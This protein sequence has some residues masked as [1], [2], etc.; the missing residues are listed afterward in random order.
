MSKE[1]EGSQRGTRASQVAGVFRAVAG[2]DADF[3]RTVERNTEGDRFF[4]PNPK[5]PAEGTVMMLEVVARESR[6][7]IV[8]A[9]VVVKAEREEAGGR[10]AGM[11]L[12]VIHIEPGCSEEVRSRSSARSSAVASTRGRPTRDR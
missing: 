5:A 9:E 10:P 7:R 8:L 12:G 3:V 6:E 4:L 2:D 1:D 11:M